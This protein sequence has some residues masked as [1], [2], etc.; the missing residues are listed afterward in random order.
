[1]SQIGMHS[2]QASVAGSMLMAGPLPDP[3]TFLADSKVLSFL[4]LLLLYRLKGCFSL[5]L[6]IGPGRAPGDAPVDWEGF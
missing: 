4:A 6:A 2:Q 5:G 1:M 3:L